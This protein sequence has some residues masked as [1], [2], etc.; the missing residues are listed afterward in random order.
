MADLTVT[1]TESV[2]LNGAARGS[3]NALTV[4]GINDVYHRVIT[5]PDDSQVAVA[6]FKSTLSNT[7]EQVLDMELVKYIR[8]TNLDASNPVILNLMIDTNE[9]DSAAD[10]SAS[11]Q[12]EAKKSF[13]YGSTVDSID[14]DDDAATIN[15]ALSSLVDL[16]SIVV[17][18][19]SE[20]V[21]VEVFIASA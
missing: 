3:S 9:D 14:V 12:I 11:I 4:S 21:Q 5:C 15:S 6:T 2:T 1:I 18:P 10:K 17:D 8:I 13:V 16:R 20:A 7:T 19:L